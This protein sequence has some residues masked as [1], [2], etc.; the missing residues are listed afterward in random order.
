MSDLPRLYTTALYNNFRPLYAN[1][2]PDR[3][4]DLGTYGILRNR[5]FI[6]LGN[7]KDRTLLKEDVNPNPSQ[8]TFSSKGT[9]QVTFHALGSAPAGGPA[10]GKA[11]LEIGFTSEDAVFFNAAGC[12]FHSVADK[13]ALGKEIMKRYV[14]GDWRREWALVTD[15]IKAG[16]TTIVVS[17]A[18][19]A[20][21][22]LE[23][24]GKVK[25][26]DLA[27][28]GLGLSVKRSTNVGYQTVSAKGLVPLFGLCKIQRKFIFWKDFGPLGTGGE[29]AESLEDAASPVSVKPDVD[30]VYFGQLM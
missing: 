25:E 19:N 16:A 27:D 29:G 8:K 14:A 26:I 15:V 7:F 5:L 11:T 12:V 17:G 3:P 1:W 30:E 20:S 13:V 22:V 9:T 4:V 18:G 23:A 6:P 10:Q 2:D 24:T 21:I 28:A